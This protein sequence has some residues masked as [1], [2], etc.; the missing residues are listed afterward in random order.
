M[1]TIK[2]LRKCTFDGSFEFN[3][4]ADRASIFGNPFVMHSEDER[5]EV[6]NLYHSY[7]KQ[8]LKSDLDFRN[9]AFRLV[10]ICRRNGKTNLYCWCSPLKCHA[11]T[12]AKFACPSGRRVQWAVEN[13][14]QP[15]DLDPTT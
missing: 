6:C 8:R 12:L 10:D 4:K 7:F 14:K 2:N 13:G 15:T 5:D 1:I 3:V 11:E 9:G